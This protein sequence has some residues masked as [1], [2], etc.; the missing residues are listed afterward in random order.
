MGYGRG[1]KNLL[2]GAG[3][4]CGD[5]EEKE[6]QVIRASNVE[7]QASESDDEKRN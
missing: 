1:H 4:F 7:G 3:K 2:T 5:G 6:V